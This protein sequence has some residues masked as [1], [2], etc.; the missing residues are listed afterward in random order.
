VIP[1]QTEFGMIEVQVALRL[2]SAASR[3]AA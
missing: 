2:S 3:R 1:K